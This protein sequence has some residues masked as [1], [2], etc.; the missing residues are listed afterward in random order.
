MCSQ[1]LDGSSLAYGISLLFVTVTSSVLVAGTG[2]LFYTYHIKDSAHNT[3]AVLFAMASFLRDV[4]SLLSLSSYARRDGPPTALT[5]IGD[6][7]S[8]GIGTSVGFGQPAAGEVCYQGN[9]SYPSQLAAQYQMKT[10]AFRYQ[11]CSG[12]QLIDVSHCQIVGDIRGGGVD[13]INCKTLLPNN[14]GKPD[15]ITASVGIEAIQYFETIT[16][17]VYFPG[18][19][20]AN[21]SDTIA[22]ANA[23]L[24]IMYMA[25]DIQNLLESTLNNT[26]DPIDPKKLYIVNY[27]LPFN[28]DNANDIN[29][30]GFAG[31]KPGL[32]TRQTVNGQILGL[33]TY[34]QTVATS[35]KATYVDVNPAFN[36]H[37]FC[38]AN[39]S[40]VWLNN[41]LSETPG[42]QA[43]KIQM[44]VHTIQDV[45][46][47]FGN[48]TSYPGNHSSDGGEYLFG[49]FHPT[50]DG[51]TAIMNAVV[52]AG[53]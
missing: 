2:C 14:F 4:T 32:S 39:S 11:G 52:K 42:F 50:E 49:A 7:F 23:S 17:C 10:D 1:R 31:N 53:S 3:F 9:V 30:P 21:C 27:P 41:P 40:D 46:D 12:A 6:S 35:L 5:S 37:R 15:M 24:N 48:V 28:V 16:N 34:L 18:V 25:S 26:G 22:A 51:H 8:A 38:D 33:N 29:C 45:W 43:G 44:S 13:Q 19:T 36:G 20:D 47:K